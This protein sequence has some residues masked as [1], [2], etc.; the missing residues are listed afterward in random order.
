MHPNDLIPLTFPLV[1]PWSWHLLLPIEITEQ[2]LAQPATGTSHSIQRSCGQKEPKSREYYASV[3]RRHRGGGGGHCSGETL[4]PADIL[5]SPV[6]HSSLMNMLVTGQREPA[7]F[8]PPFI[9][10]MQADTA[11]A[12]VQH[13]AGKKALP[14]RWSVYVFPHPSVNIQIPLPTRVCVVQAAQP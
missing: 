11:V 10:R 6:S 9:T 7:S 2:V 3:S 8:F 12:Y 14:T 5:T 13:S 1:P 4:W